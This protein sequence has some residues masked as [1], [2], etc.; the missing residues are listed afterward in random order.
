MVAMLVAGESGAGKT[1]TLAGVRASRGGLVAHVLSDLFTMLPPDAELSVQYCE[2]SP[3]HGRSEHALKDLINPAH[4][5]NRVL[6]TAEDGVPV[7]EGL[8]RRPVNTAADAIALYRSGT[9]A[10]TLEPAAK[11]DAALLF[12]LHLALGDVRS[13]FLVAKLPGAESLV[14]NEAHA[15]LTNDGRTHNAM[16]EFESMVSQL[17][18]RPAGSI[19]S[20]PGKLVALLTE[21]LGGNCRTAVIFTL[22]DTVTP[23]TQRLLVLAAKLSNVSV[24]WSAACH[25]TSQAAA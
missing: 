16:R 22:L 10:R 23:V 9:A 5:C 24:S 1:Y 15:R 11:D 19:H 20:Q 6:E 25:Q 3:V 2:I 18:G 17:S 4:R 7:I 8:T 14:A 12:F 13:T 21:A